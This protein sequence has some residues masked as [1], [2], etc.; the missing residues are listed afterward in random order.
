MFFADCTKPGSCETRARAL[1]SGLPVLLD[2]HS[3]AAHAWNVHGIPT[4]FVIDKKG[5]QVAR[6]EGSADWSTPAAAELVRKL[7]S[8]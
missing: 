6:L 2:P 4:S 8:M 1:A 3:T 5:R 7:V